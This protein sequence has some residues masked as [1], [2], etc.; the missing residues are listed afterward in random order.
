MRL[1]HLERS[2]YAENG[3]LDD[4]V[5]PVFVTVLERNRATG[6]SLEDRVAR[7]TAAVAEVTGRHPSHVHVLFEDD[8]AGRLSF[9]GRLVE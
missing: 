3:G 4:E 7:V 2:R 5:C 1:R 6:R 9:G 8:A